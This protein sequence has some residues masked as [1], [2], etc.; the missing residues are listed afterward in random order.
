MPGARWFIPTMYL[1]VVSSLVKSVPCPRQRLSKYLFS[2]PVFT[3]QTNTSTRHLFPFP[4]RTNPT[5]HE[6]F[7]L[8]RSA[9]QN[10]IKTRC[11]NHFLSSHIPTSCVVH[12]I[13]FFH[14][15]WI[16][17]PST[18]GPVGINKITSLSRC[19]TLMQPTASTMFRPRYV[20]PGSAPSRMPM[21]SSVVELV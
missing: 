17:A 2:Q 3:R 11:E 18:A 7:H 14:P 6:I 9:S 1:D 20:M 12:T 10:E 21:A 5:P 4:P 8:P 16:F 15:F 19:T 13:Q